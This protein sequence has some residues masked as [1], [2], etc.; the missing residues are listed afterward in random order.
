MPPFGGIARSGK[1]RGQEPHIFVDELTRYARQATDQRIR[2]LA[3]QAGA[4]LRVAVRGRPGVGA[5]TV[6]RAL[7]RAS[8][9]SVV[10]AGRSADLVV[11]V[12][13]DVVKPEDRTSPALV[14]LTKAD[15]LRLAGDARVEA[16]CDRLADHV[17]V[18]VL[19]MC[20][21]LAVAALDDLDTRCWAALRTLAAHPG[22]LSCLDGSF[23]GFLGAQLPVPVAVRTQLLRVLDLFGIALGVA[24]LR[25][26]AGAAQVRALWRRVSG[27]DAVLERLLSAGAAVRY[28]RVLDAV[29]ELE[30]L[31][32]SDPAVGDFLTRDETVIAR[33]AAALDVVTAAGQ[34]AGP[35]APLARAVHWQ[36]HRAGPHGA[37]AADIA[38]GSL[39]LWSR[40]GGAVPRESR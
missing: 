30:A 28:R 23:D 3:E 5:R 35:E 32:V 36:R 17:G 20:G 6:A 21:L 26:G 12:I 29:T 38:R 22:G 27:V 19:P 40:S 14:V 9:I 11:Q 1:S 25:Q 15:V 13:A 33:M 37:C 24:A 39:R 18:P 16:R 4:P 8:G 2:A 31:A 34:A 10:A 7:D